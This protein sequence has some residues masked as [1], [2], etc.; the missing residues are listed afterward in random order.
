VS[1]VR[2]ISAGLL[3]GLALNV[4][5]AVLHGVVLADATAEAMTALGRTETG[6]GVGLAMLIGITFVQ[7]VLGV[8]L[9]G[10]LSRGR[11]KRVATSVCAGLTVWTLSAV[12]SAVYLS[13]GLPSLLPAA[14]VWWPVAWGLVEYP[15]AIFIGALVYRQG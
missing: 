8:W 12:Y 2:M 13:A 7:G 6:S 14:V 10:L 9:Y 1:S 4:G 3:A 5:E 15:L 11:E